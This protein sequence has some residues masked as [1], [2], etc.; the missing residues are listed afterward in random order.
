M[1]ISEDPTNVNLPPLYEE[2]LTPFQKLMLLKVLREEELIFGVKKFVKEELGKKFIESPPF[3]LG[4]SYSDSSPSTP[5]IFILSP[6][7]DP[8]VYLLNLAQEKEMDGPKFRMLSLGQGQG[9]K[10][11]ELIIQGR[12]NG[13]WVCLQNCHLYTSYM[14]E[15]ERIQET[16][17]EDEMHGDYRLWLTSMPSRT[18]PVPVLQSGIKLTNEPPRGLKANLMRTFDEVNE[19]FYE[20]CSKPR[21]LKKMLFALA[22]FHAVILER[23]KFGAIGWNIPYEWMNSDFETSKAQLKMYLDEQKNVPYK[24]LN[25]LTAEINYGGRVT[26]D[27]DERLIK[28]LLLNLFCPDV[29]NDGYPLSTLKTYYVPEEGSLQSVKDYIEQLPLDDDPQV[30]GMHPNANITFQQKTVR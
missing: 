15:L 24:A 10:A 20:S 11:T 17:N 19:E 18:F 4:S 14:A 23:R 21:A 1:V 8:M 26:D 16:G 7:A 29:M 28:A 22:F 9:K 2:R 27:K 12:T 25:Y 3:D 13:D 6:G 5:I 30:Y